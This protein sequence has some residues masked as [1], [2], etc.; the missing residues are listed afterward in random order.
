MRQSTILYIEGLTVEF[1]GFRAIDGLS[2]YVDCGELRFLIGPNG[3]GKTTLLDVI[4]GKT[5]PQR[6]RVIFK[7]NIDVLR[8]KEHELVSLGI[9]RKFQTPSVFDELT[10]Y[11]NM[12]IALK[13]K[14]GIL[15][16]IFSK[17]INNE[18][19]KIL[20]TLEL[21]GLLNKRDLKA[22][23]L[24]HGEKQ[25]LEIAMLLVQ[26][27]ELILLDEPVAGLSKEER[28]KMGQLLKNILNMRSC[29]ILI[30]EHDMNFVRQ[31]ARRITVMHEGKILCEGNINTIQEDPKVAEVYLGRNRKENV[32]H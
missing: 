29:S 3:A 7:D 16:S 6:G 18:E 20:E 8:K 11:E 10:V 1:D 17:K 32:G 12:E 22:S 30:V 5:K 31:F 14:K 13:R 26:E 28:T 9:G 4:C 24:S 2:M 19:K 15:S 21:T 27:A 25:I 23:H